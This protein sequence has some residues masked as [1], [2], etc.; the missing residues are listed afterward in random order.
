MSLLAT[1]CT[2]LPKAQPRDIISQSYDLPGALE[3]NAVIGAVER[4]FV[5]TLA[6]PPR[7]IEGSVPSPLPTVPAQFMVEDRHVHLDRLGVVSM[8]EVVCPGSMA[9]V[10]AVV[11]DR[12]ESSGPH[13]YTGCI[14]SY[15][16][17]YRV[18]IVDS[19]MM[20]L[21]RRDGFAG[22]MGAD[23]TSYPDI[24]SRLAR[25]LVEQV[26]DARPVTDMSAIEAVVPV[27]QT[28]TKASMDHASL[29]GK[30]EESLASPLGT[31]MAHR[32]NNAVSILPLVCLAPRHESAPVRT[33]R[34]EG[35][36]ITL[37]DRD[38]IKAVAEPVDAS[39]FLVETEAGTTGWVNGSD[40]RRLPCPIG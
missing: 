10:R 14:Q 18:H 32:E 20:V 11:A 2:L 4:A 26:S 39:Y 22:P 28:S 24:V 8:P 38:S 33:A 15:A 36:V 35:H 3:A 30:R 21:E 40:V 37:L 1:G 5:R 29:T 9:I 13:S 6:M 34:G 25:A 31:S 7:I 12:S 16:G 23:P 17:G 27:Q 19:A